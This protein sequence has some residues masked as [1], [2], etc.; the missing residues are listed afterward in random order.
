MSCDYQY[1]DPVQQVRRYQ[2]ME[3]TVYELRRQVDEY[4]DRVAE[5]E[6]KIERLKSVGQ[7]KRGI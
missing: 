7:F 5:L 3:R 1:Q 2:E 4:R 6:G